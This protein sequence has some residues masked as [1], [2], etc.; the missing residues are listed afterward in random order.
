MRIIQVTYS[1]PSYERH[2][3]TFYGKNL[4]EAM[5]LAINYQSTHP[6]LVDVKTVVENR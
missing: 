1:N 3:K 2:T 6:E 5:V 4:T